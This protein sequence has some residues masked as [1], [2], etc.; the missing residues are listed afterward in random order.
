[1]LLANAPA[2]DSTIAKHRF[3]GVVLAEREGKPLY[4]K[5]N[6]RGAGPDDIWRWASTTKQLTAL[7]VMQEVEAGR[8]DLDAPVTRYWP[9]WPQPNAARG[10][11]A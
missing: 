4:A 11:L 6:D 1:M 5:A 3:T 9:D 2:L 7:I 10:W 8:F